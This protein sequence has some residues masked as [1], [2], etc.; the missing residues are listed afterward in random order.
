[1]TASQSR[2]LI[3]QN[4]SGPKSFLP[5]VVCKCENRYYTLI[6]VKNP[7]SNYYCLHP[8]LRVQQI[9]IGSVERQLE[10]VSCDRLIISII[11]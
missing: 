1:M 6:L 9:Q 10:V 5:S 3:G 4:D 8:T 11:F 2:G 7:I